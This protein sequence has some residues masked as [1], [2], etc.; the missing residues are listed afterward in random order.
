MR[1]PISTKG[2][3]VMGIFRGNKGKPWTP[4]ENERV[5]SSYFA[6]LRC[7]L[8]GRSFNKSRRHKRL[9]ALLNGRSEKAVEFKLQNITA[10]LHGM[11]ELWVEGYK[12][13]FNFQDPLVAVVKRHLEKN[14]E[15]LVKAAMALQSSFP[16]QPKE[17]EVSPPPALPGRLT[18][19]KL[20]KV[21]RVSQDFDVAARDKYNR[22]LG[23]Q[24]E[25][26]VYE[27]EKLILRKAGLD[28]LADKVV[29][30]SRDLGDGAGYDI[31]S[32]SPDHR[33]RLIEVKTTN[34]WGRTPFYVTRNERRVSREKHDE[35]HLFRLWD[36]MRE[37]KAF[38]LTSA[39]LEKCHWT[40]TGYQVR[41]SD[42]VTES[43]EV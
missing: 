26:R 43:Q 15:S 39:Q 5:V 1:Y 9:S 19:K 11:G 13:R 14:R 8:A 23:Q 7:E 35:W 20:A 16:T 27:H 2:D 3:R 10:V 4:E 34:G 28:S 24:G 25:R 36:F 32:Y 41:L 22:E 33:K 31:E 30:V 42:T 12:P 17:I 37:P 38:E 18:L 40:A 29:W 21:Y 6:M